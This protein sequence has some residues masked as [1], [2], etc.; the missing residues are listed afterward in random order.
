MEQSNSLIPSPTKRR[1]WNKDKL[2]GPK[3]PLRSKHVWSIRTKLQLEGRKRGLALFNLAID[4]KLRGCGVVAVKV[5]DVAVKMHPT[6]TSPESKGIVLIM[7]GYLPFPR[8]HHWEQNAAQKILTFIKEINE[9]D[10]ITGGVNV[11]CVF[12]Q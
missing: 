8:G 3:P 12:T 5:E 7:L 11:G 10:G 9:L 1:P 4:C 2:I 6:L